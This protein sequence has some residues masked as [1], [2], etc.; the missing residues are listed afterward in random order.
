MSD[1][2]QFN[3]AVQV[4][5][6]GEAPPD[7]CYLTVNR[8][9]KKRVAPSGPHAASS[10]DAD[11]APT[12]T[13]VLPVAGNIVCD[14]LLTSSR[15]DLSSF[16]SDAPAWEAILRERAASAGLDLNSGQ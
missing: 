7:L 15:H 14:D 10:S 1:A 5:N 3:V 16:A 8:S 6:P 13:P 4:S 12:C 2:T 9:P 11:A